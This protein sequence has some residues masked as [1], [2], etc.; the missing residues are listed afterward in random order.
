MAAT[1][2]RGRKAPQSLYRGVFWHTNA[3]KWRAS[4]RGKHLGCFT[5]QEE[6]LTAY[7]AA[8]GTPAPKQSKPKS[9]RR[10][11]APSLPLRM[12]KDC[13]REGQWIVWAVGPFGECEL[14]NIDRCTCDAFQKDGH[15]RHYD[16]V[17]GTEGQEAA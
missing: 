12:L 14:V 9:I 7:V 11:S 17:F 10:Q 3:R 4:H 13:A 2:E 1:R 5:T 16:F 8:G 6:A 15:C